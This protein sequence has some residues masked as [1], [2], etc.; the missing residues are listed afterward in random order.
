VGPLGSAKTLIEYLTLAGQTIRPWNYFLSGSTL[1]VHA[2]SP[3]FPAFIHPGSARTGTDRPP[4][5]NSP[6]AGPASL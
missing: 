4:Y 3:E 6:R 5:R 2:H 1:N